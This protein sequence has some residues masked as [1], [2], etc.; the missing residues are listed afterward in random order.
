MSAGIIKT[1]GG[2]PEQTS[3]KVILAVASGEMD[4]AAFAAWVENHAFQLE[5]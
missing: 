4:E 2:A 1:F 5:D 3:A